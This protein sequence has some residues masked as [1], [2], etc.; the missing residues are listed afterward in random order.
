MCENIC[1]P[2]DDELME[3]CGVFSNIGT[4]QSLQQ[5]ISIYHNKILFC[6]GPNNFQEK[7]LIQLT[8]LKVQEYDTR[9]TDPWRGPHGRCHHSGGRRTERSHGKTVS[10]RHGGGSL[11]KDPSPPLNT[12]L[13]SKLPA[14][15]LLGIHSNHI[16]TLGTVMNM[17]Y[18]CSWRKACHFPKEA[19]VGVNTQHEGLTLSVS[20]PFLEGVL[21]LRPEINPD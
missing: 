20:G 14:Y 16:Q 3:D 5:C 12:I 17:Y 13:G 2:L 1:F 4:L 10:Q 8:V 15:I 7:G 18:V 9:I 6:L 19:C 11:L 21:E